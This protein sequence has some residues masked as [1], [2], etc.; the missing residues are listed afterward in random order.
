M[1]FQSGDRN[2]LSGIA[3]L[4]DIVSNGDGSAASQAAVRSAFPA[5]TGSGFTPASG[6][7]PNVGAYFA[8]GQL[9]I[10]VGGANDFPQGVAFFDS[11]LVPGVQVGVTHVNRTA[12]AAAVQLLA[13]IDATLSFPP[14][15]YVLAGHSYGGGVAQIVAAI[16]RSQGRR[17]PIYLF[18]EGAPRVGDEFLGAA[19]LG[20][21]HARL[22]TTA[23]PIPIFPPHWT[24]APFAV[25]LL[26][27]L[28]AQNLAYWVQPP[29][30]LELHDDGTL[31]PG[32][33]PG[34][35]SSIRDVDLLA[36][37][38]GGKGVSATAHRTG[39]YRRLLGPWLIAAPPVVFGDGFIKGGE[40]VQVPDAN[41][42]A[43]GP[44]V[45]PAFFQEVMA[46]AYSS[47]YIPVPHQ[48]RAEKVGLTW[49]ATWEGRLVVKCQ[50][51]SQARSVSKA[52]NKQLRV[53]QN[54]ASIDHLAF[55]SSLQDYLTAASSG[56]AGFMPVVTVT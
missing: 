21:P 5:N 41:A 4:L 34:Y 7:L 47:V 43:L 9:V 33:T 17:A 14:D 55:G 48:W 12:F 6:L 8:D 35:V 52:G 18:T 20:V 30:G 50:S 45:G 23:D 13:L 42:F 40:L 15:E 53:L 37:L 39:T 28:E 1:P 3:Y 24:E 10:I 44:V 56:T 26:G 22:F 32:L 54:A 49:Y 29:G 51:R 46:M 38:Y 31:T 25:S 2:S 16:M 36:W 27:L 11:A 19:L